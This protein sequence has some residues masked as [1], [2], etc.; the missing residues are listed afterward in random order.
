MNH[1]HSRSILSTCAAALLL[2]LTG[3]SSDGAPPAEEAKEGTAP[4]G[5]HISDDEAIF[6]TSE[7]EL[8]PGK[9]K[10]LCYA[11]T[12][13]EDLVVDSYEHHGAATLHHV[14]FNRTLVAEPDG[15]S[16][17]DVLFR[18]TWEP[19]YLAGAGSSRLDFPENTAHR[20]TKGTQLLV[21]LHLLNSSDEPVKDSLEI[22]LHRSKAADPDAVNV[23]IFGNFNVEVP[24]LKKSTVEATCAVK[25]TVNL[26][27][28]FPHMHML[29]KELTFEAGP[30]ADSMTR[31][32]QRTPYSFD[33]QRL[34]PL[35]L[36]LAA[37]D[38]THIT[39]GYDNPHNE[40]ITFGESTMNE[41]CFLIGFAVRPTIGG[42][43]EGTPPPLQ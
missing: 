29:G 17:C 11:A 31:K 35:D 9:E 23:Y 19:M 7:Y 15:L 25:D 10:Y 4:A 16:E 37:G 28:A 3:C 26:I 13:D 34:E 18:Y 42:C 30:S 8:A 40:T 2:A 14:A 39:C 33:D 21:Q 36:T 6:R 20:I 12:V 43:F 32:Y 5:I 41:M 27:A 24:P 38:T 1:A 22:K